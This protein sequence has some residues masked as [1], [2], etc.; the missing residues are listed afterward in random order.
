M[1]VP[2]FLK[3]LR[4]NNQRITDVADPSTATD[5]ANKQYVDAVAAGRDW[6]ESVRAATTADITLSGAQTIDGVSV[7]AGDRVLVKNESSGADNG[8]YVAAAGAWSRAA[9]ADTAADLNPGATVS[10]EEGTV[11]G[12]KRF[13]LTTNLPFTLGTTAQVWTVDASGG[14]YTADGQGI[15]LSASQF[16]LELDGTSLSKSAS[17]LKVNDAVVV[18]KYAADCAATT[19]PQTFTHGLGTNDV[20]VEVWETN[21]KVFPDVTKGSG[22]V[23]IDWGSAPT[24]AQYRVVIQG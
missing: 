20:Q 15:E 22:T 11:N 1:A 17:G 2:K 9:D 10:V 14:S 19:N 24:A 6:K 3:G 4:V 16:S 7:I 18:K 23:I 8:I 21:D 5:A 13:T 12:D